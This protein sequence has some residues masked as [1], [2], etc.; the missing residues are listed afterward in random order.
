MDFNWKLG[1]LAKNN[2]YKIWDVNVFDYEWVDT[3]ET[4]YLKDFTD[5]IRKDFKVY[6]IEL[7]SEKKYFAV[8]P[9][10]KDTWLFYY[11]AD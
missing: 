2:L 11:N 7:N 3:N 4:A 5:G 6:Y 8:M 10:G 9:R 1:K